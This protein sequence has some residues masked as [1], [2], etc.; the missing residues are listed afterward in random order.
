LVV[1]GAISWTYEWHRSVYRYIQSL[2]SPQQFL[3]Q[4]F[5][6]SDKIPKTIVEQTVVWDFPPEGK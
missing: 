4:L 2:H 6:A 5:T 3:H 1:V